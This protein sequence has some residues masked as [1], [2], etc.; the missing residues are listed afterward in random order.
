MAR[1]FSFLQNKCSRSI[2]AK[3]N[4]LRKVFREANNLT[5]VAIFVIIPNVKNDVLLV[6]RNDCSWTIH[7]ACARVADA[8]GGNEFLRIGVL[9]LLDE[10]TLQCS[11]TKDF[12]NI[13]A[14]RLFINR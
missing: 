11:V 14:A 4:N 6:F 9:N 8:I 13:V 10:F 1:P 2:V 3:A 7:N 12:V 5:A